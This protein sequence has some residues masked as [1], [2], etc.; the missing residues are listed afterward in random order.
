MEPIIK[1][2][3]IL[4]DVEVNNKEEILGQMV[5]TLAQEGYLSDR[6]QYYKD[7]LD[8]ECVFPTSI[9]H[10]IGIP[11]GKSSGVAH[12]GI[13]A[14]KL[15]R[16]VVW[17]E[18]AEEVDFIVLIAVNDQ[19]QGNFHL[20]ILSQLSRLMMHE[21]FRNSMKRGTAEGIYRTLIDNLGGV[22]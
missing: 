11:H 7:V 20:K 14:A 9:G 12:A 6:D 2:E 19:Q 3:T 18:N 1:K 10:G 5:D 4:Y 22:Q 17:D 15:T 16:P 8:R 13:C 21:E